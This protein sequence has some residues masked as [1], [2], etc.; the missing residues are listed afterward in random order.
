MLANHWGFTVKHWAPCYCQHNHYDNF[1][2]LMLAGNAYNVQFGH[3]PKYWTKCWWHFCIDRIILKTVIF[4]QFSQVWTV[5]YVGEP[6]FEILVFNLFES[7]SGDKF[8]I[9]LLENSEIQYQLPSLTGRNS[10][11]TWTLD[12]RSA[13]VAWSSFVKHMPPFVLCN[14]QKQAHSRIVAIVVTS[15]A[16]C[17]PGDPFNNEQLS[18]KYSL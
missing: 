8:V 11:L 6:R 5:G 7:S 3:K 10:I 4:R 13:A 14:A 18:S 16:T 1:N 17:S 9:C 15:K 2:M 12:L